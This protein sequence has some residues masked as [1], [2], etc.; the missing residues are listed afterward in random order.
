MLSIYE[1]S[2]GAC[3]NNLT[4]VS[5]LISPKIKSLYVQL[6]YP[7]E[8]QRHLYIL[9]RESSHS[10]HVGSEKQ[11]KFTVW[12]LRAPKDLSATV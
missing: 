1:R 12:A 4:E 11:L 5:N 7:C 2:Q 3:S 9:H 6:V 10:V 8:G